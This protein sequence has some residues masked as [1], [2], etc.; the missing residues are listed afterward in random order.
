MIGPVFFVP[1][2]ILKGWK[3]VAP[4]RPIEALMMNAFLFTSG[5]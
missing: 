4:A 3:I 5:I 2:M 1:A